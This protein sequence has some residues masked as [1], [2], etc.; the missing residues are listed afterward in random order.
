MVSFHRNSVVKADSTEII[1]VVESSENGL[2][3]PAYVIEHE[4]GWLPNPIRKQKFGLDETKK[5]LFA[6]EDEL[7]EI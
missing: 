5:Y 6:R 4:S 3:Q 7:T 2:Q 1:A